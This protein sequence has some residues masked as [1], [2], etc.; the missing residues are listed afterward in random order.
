MEC[1]NAD[2]SCDLQSEDPWLNVHVGAPGS[3]SANAIK[4]FLKISLK[5]PAAV[6]ASRKFARIKDRC[7]VG[8]KG[9]KF[10]S[11]KVVECLDE[12]PEGLAYLGLRSA[13][14]RGTG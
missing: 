4:H 8:K 7:V 14:G 11:L 10:L 5:F 6:G 1:N 13:V 3:A 12:V 9:P 2:V